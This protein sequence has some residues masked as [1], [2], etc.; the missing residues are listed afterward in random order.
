MTRFTRDGSTGWFQSR[1]PSLESGDTHSVKRGAT[2]RVVGPWIIVWLA[3]AASIFLRCRHLGTKSL[4]FDEGYTAWLV[5][6]SPHEIIRLIRADTAPPLYYLLLHE[7][8]LVFGRSEAALRSLSTVFSILTLLVAIDIARRFLPSP[9]AIAAAACAMA[10]SFMQLW[11]AKEA[12]CYAM[13]AFLIVAAFDCL[14]L[15]L[16]SRYRRWLIFLPILIAAAMYTHN[17]MAPYVVALLVAWLVLPSQHRLPRRIGEIAAVTLLAGLLYLPWA[18]RGLPDQMQMIHNGFWADPLK[19]GKFFLVLAQTAGVLHYWS[20]VHM[21]HHFHL[22]FLDGRYPILWTMILL[23]ASA[24]LSLFCQLGARRRQA[25]GLL[26]LALLPLLFVAIYSLLETSLFIDKLF[27]PSAT[28]MPI[29]ALIPLSMPLPRMGLRAAWVGAI[30][31]LL[32]NAATLYGYRIEGKKENWRGAA[33][34]VANLPPVHRLIIFVAND[35]QLPFDYY[36][37][38]RPGDEV[39]GV[40][41]GFFD[42]D[43]P[44]TMRRVMKFSDL[45]PLIARLNSHHYDQIVLLISHEF[46]GDPNYLT[47]WL[48]N[49][50]YSLVGQLALYD[51]KVQWYRPRPGR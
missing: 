11:Y 37:H 43:P 9:A 32:L 40:P 13:T 16:A 15:H 3:V 33:A 21:I 31:M 41:G 36:Y 49:R 22:V 25:A 26:I 44:R 4:W 35:G 12:R 5:S 39:T 23:S 17:M 34:T 6:H 2:L 28:L 1:L 14:L 10:L 38:Y 48:I 45:D 42:L 27:L 50:R 29:F 30:A 24:F 7:W 47:R 20:T 19:R 46:W 51:V 18:I 8:T